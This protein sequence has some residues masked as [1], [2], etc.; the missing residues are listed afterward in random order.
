LRDRDLPGSPIFGPNRLW[1]RTR[2][3]SGQDHP[4]QDES[5][6]QTGKD[7]DAEILIQSAR[8]RSAKKR[9]GRDQWTDFEVERL[10]APRRPSEFVRLDETLQ[11]LESIDSRQ[12]RIVELR[13]FGGLSIEETAVALDCSASTVVREWRLAKAWLYRELSGGRA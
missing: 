12:C 3:L 6:I 11:V 5:D 13:Y 7:P 4:D 10:L 8:R 2:N 9:I 1:S